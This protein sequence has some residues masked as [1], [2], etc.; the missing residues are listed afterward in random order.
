MCEKSVFQHKIT[1]YWCMYIFCI[2]IQHMRVSK[3]FIHT[4]AFSSKFGNSIGFTMTI[5]CAASLCTTPLKYGFCF[6]MK[7]NA[8]LLWVRHSV[9]WLTL[10]EYGAETCITVARNHSVF[11]II[12]ELLS[13]KYRKHNR[14]RAATVSKL[15]LNYRDVHS[16]CLQFCCP[17]SQ[18]DQICQERVFPSFPCILN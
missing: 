18:H 14:T 13:V 1:I 16:A 17:Y 12:T 2:Q 3:P 10:A 15:M 6:F 8:H 4:R 7:N 9:L 11:P 5:V